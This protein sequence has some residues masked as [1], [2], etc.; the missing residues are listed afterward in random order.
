MSVLVVGSV[1]IDNII[2]EDSRADNVLGGSASYASV[3]I[4]RFEKA[5]LVGIVGED[6]PAE[7]IEL[8]KRNNVDTAGLVTVKGGKTFTWTGKYRP[9]FDDRETLDIQLNT[10]ADFHPKIPGAYKKS[11]F[12]LLANIQP[13]LQMEVMDQVKENEFVMADT[14][15]LWINTTREDLEK[16]IT[17]V[18]ALVLNDSEAVLYTGS[19]NLINAARAL[20]SQG[21]KIVIVK[22]GSHGAMLFNGDSIF[23]IPACPIPGVVDPTGAGDTFAGAIMGFL[24]SQGKVNDELLRRA[25][26][27][28]TVVA[29][30]TVEAFSLRAIDGLS[31]D[32]IQI[33]YD[34]IKEMTRF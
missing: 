12:V 21:P 34:Q 19:S 18:D 29:S 15:D 20:Q 6:F 14:M 31:R 11:K 27:Y 16:L 4:G 13:S 23:S 22:K 9:N 26:V 33:R 8:Y 24:A 3:A 30:Y 10:F 1:A 28:G 25:L 5:N 7:Y 2:T 17:K 32:K